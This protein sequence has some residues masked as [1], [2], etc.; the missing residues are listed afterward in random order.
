MPLI[1]RLLLLTIIG[2]QHRALT[3]AFALMRAE[4]DYYR[5]L[6]PKDTKLRFTPAWRRTFGV[7]GKGVGWSALE[8]IA[9]VASIRTFQRWYK[10]TTQAP[11]QLANKIG[12]PK[13]PAWVEMQVLIMAYAT[14]WGI[15]RIAGAITNLGKKIHPKTVRRILRDNHFDPG[16]RKLTRPESHWKPF[17]TEHGHEIAAMDFLQTDVWDWLGKRT[18]YVLFL[19]HIK[20]RRVEIAGITEHPNAEWMKQVARNLTMADIGFFPLTN[21]KYLIRD[22]DQIYQPSFDELLRTADVETVHIAPNS[23]NLNSFAERWVRS[24]KSECLRKVR[25]V[26]IG[27]LQ[28]ALQEY[29]RHYH[30]ERNHQG[31]GNVLI[32]SEKLVADL[33]VPIQCRS[34][35]GGILK[36]YYRDAA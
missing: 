8:K 32:A 22:N 34:R 30:G 31:I 11:A 18:V 13:I 6:V 2:H 1:L 24:V 3:L 20:T 26:G 17:I 4:R 9:T 14:S 28:R 15:T 29:L 12:R 7:L 33:K 10:L 25:C 21:S 5:S 19:I 16:Q 36:Y 27:G 35:L 23:P